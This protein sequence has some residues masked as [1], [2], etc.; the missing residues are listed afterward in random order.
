[1][2]KLSKSKKKMEEGDHVP[3]FR[4]LLGKCSKGE[5]RG[6][7]VQAQILF[8]SLFKCLAMKATFFA[9]V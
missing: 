1:M 3:H 9:L 6:I 5:G 7:W 4:S 8:P 2:Q